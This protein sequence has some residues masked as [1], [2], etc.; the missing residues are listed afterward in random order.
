MRRKVRMIAPLLRVG[1][2]TAVYLFGL[3]SL[4]PGDILT[5]LVLASLLV[6]VRRR[7]RPPGPPPPVPLRGRLAGVPALLGGSLVDLIRSTW[8]TAAWLVARSPSPAGLLEVP[9]PPCTPSSGAAW[10][11]RVGLSPDTVVV[12][13]DEVHG[14]M[15]LHVIDVRDP[16]AAVAAQLDAYRRRQRRA[17]P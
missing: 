17:F 16:E 15:L 3:T 1:G 4:K 8:H 6:A 10:G 14:R 5:G 9:I 13:L 7:V 2:L 11:V 12:E